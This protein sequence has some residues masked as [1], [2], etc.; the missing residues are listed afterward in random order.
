[1]SNEQKYITAYLI[2]KYRLNAG[3]ALKEPKKDPQRLRKPS[4]MGKIRELFGDRTTL[5]DAVLTNIESQ[6]S[7]HREPTPEELF[8][9]SSALDVPMIALIVDQEDPFA[10]CPLSQGTKTNHEVTA[11]QSIYPTNIETCKLANQLVFFL[12][13]A[14]LN[15]DQPQFWG[16]GLGGDPVTEEQKEIMKK[17]AE[18]DF[19]NLRL[20]AMELQMKGVAIPDS[21]KAS[22]FEVADLLHEAY[23][24]KDLRM[25]D[26]W[27]E[28]KLE[29]WK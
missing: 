3:L 28:E 9:I 17:K 15:Y 25:P 20:R 6:G 2:K 27:T 26:Y 13:I 16:F 24:S 22:F 7:R 14:K 18:D 12:E 5:T 23:G 29:Q 19:D 4:L 1:M 8:Q 11:D 21:V 10:P